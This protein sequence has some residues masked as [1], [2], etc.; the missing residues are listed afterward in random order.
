MQ[1]SAAK[2][3]SFFRHRDR[4]PG[5]FLK[6]VSTDLPQRKTHLNE[7]CSSIIIFFNNQLFWKQL[8]LTSNHLWCPVL[9]FVTWDGIRWDEL[10][11]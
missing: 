11:S 2:R 4:P 3:F 8:F 9:T 1:T 7:Q 10:V 6:G 5:G